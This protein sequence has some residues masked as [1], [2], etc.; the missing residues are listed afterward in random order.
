MRKKRIIDSDLNIKE[1]NVYEKM[2]RY[3]IVD[4]KLNEYLKIIKQDYL[5][6]FM[7]KYELLVKKLDYFK[8]VLIYSKGKYWSYNQKINNCRKFKYGMFGDHNE[9]F[10]INDDSVSKMLCSS[11]KE[12]NEYKIIYCNVYELWEVFSL[13]EAKKVSLNFQAYLDDVLKEYEKKC[14]VIKY[15]IIKVVWDDMEKNG[16]YINRKHELLSRLYRLNLFNDEYEKVICVVD[17]CNKDELVDQ[18]VK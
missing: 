10:Y 18:F 9:T 7:K 14:D 16:N 5:E 15:E 2:V 12:L 13:E 4:E 8:V 1:C 6:D 11:F 3:H 17:N